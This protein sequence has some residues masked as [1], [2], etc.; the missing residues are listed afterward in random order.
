[1]RETTTIEIDHETREYAEAIAKRTGETPDE[2]IRRATHNYL[3]EP[4]TIAQ[5]ARVAQ[6]SVR[7][8]NNWLRAGMG[9]SKLGRIVRISHTDL[10]L[11]INRHKFLSP[12][13]PELPAASLR[14][15][16][17]VEK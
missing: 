16:K 17:K 7:T 6:V 15:R 4:L 13:T 1:M 2:V 9:H 3:H 14:G 12:S 5:A 11:W 8:I 10:H